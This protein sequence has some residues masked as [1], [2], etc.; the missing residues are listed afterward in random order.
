MLSYSDI[1]RRSMSITGFCKCRCPV[2][3]VLTPLQLGQHTWPTI[4]P[5]FPWTARCL[6]SYATPDGDSNTGMAR[7]TTFDMYHLAC[8]WGLFVRLYRWSYSL[9]L[10][11]L[12]TGA[13]SHWSASLRL[14]VESLLVNPRLFKS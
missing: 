3:G 7:F 12:S 11:M 4:F 13:G 10:L 2:G 1:P 8:W 5:V 6:S 9:D 14:E